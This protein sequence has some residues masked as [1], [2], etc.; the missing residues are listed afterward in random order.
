MIFWAA[1]RTVET[2]D[3]P[4]RLTPFD[5]EV[6]EVI[7]GYRMR[8]HAEVSDY[9]RTP[10]TVVQNAVGRLRQAGVPV[11]TNTGHSF[12]SPVEVWIG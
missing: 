7:S 9:L 10:H 3:G 11:A 5:A 12:H 1:R 6:L 8:S 2:D 4:V